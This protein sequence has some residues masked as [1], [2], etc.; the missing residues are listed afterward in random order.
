MAK[1]PRSQKR[2]LADVKR[3]AIEYYEATKRPLGATGEIAEYE[4]SQKLGLKLADARTPG[5]DA[6]QKVNG[7]T[8]RIQIKGRRPGSG[9]IYRGRV[10]RIN[11]E[12]N[13]QCVMLVL[14][15]E[16]YN[17]VE[18]WKASRI[19]VKR[20]LEAK[21]SASRNKRGSM[22]IRQFKS[23]AKC[24]WRSKAMHVSKA[25]RSQLRCSTGPPAPGNRNS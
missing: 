4:A 1:K 14:M 5:Y 9:D 7:R 18:I 12:S 20:R 24:V 19:A 23:I 10:P 15:D 11:L 21:G 17:A 2:I 3:L 6:T 25:K 22:G 8:V 13:F 16:R